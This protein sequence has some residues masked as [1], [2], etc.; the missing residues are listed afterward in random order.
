MKDFNRLALFAVPSGSLIPLITDCPL[1]APALKGIVDEFEDSRVLLR[2]Y[3]RL[4]DQS[5][6]NLEQFFSMPL[7]VAPEALIVLGPSA[8]RQSWKNPLRSFKA[9]SP[10]L[11]SLARG[12]AAAWDALPERWFSFGPFGLQVGAP[13]HCGLSQKSPVEGAAWAS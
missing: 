12:G 7:E 10:P 2:A 13:L 5:C 8:A 4:P 3:A 1:L 11:G 6:K 9:A